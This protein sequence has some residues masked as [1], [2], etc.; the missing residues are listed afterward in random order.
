MQSLADLSTSYR[1]NVEGVQPL[2]FGTRDV[3]LLFIVAQL[4]AVPILLTQVPA[5]QALGRIARI[6]TGRL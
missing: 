6:L 4:P 1:D 3:L 5:Q 2:L